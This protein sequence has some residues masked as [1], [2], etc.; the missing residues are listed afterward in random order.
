MEWGIVA[1][2]D[3]GRDSPMNVGRRWLSLHLHLA[4]G[5]AGCVIA[6][7]ASGHRTLALMA[8]P[9]L[10]A[11]VMAYKQ[12]ACEQPYAYWTAW[13]AAAVSLALGAWAEPRSAPVAPVLAL[14]SAAVGAVLFILWCAHR[15]R[16]HPL[17]DE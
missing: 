16:R 1:S 3:A 15:H 8:I 2:S 14:V 9:L 17:V 10:M 6:A 7:V 11:A 5:A 12:V 13:A 4:G